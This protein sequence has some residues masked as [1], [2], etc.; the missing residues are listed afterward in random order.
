MSS[1]ENLSK[2]KGAIAWM[3]QNPVASN[4]FMFVLLFAGAVGL[5]QTKQEVLPEFDIGI[6][7]VIVPYPGAA[8]EEVEQ[9]IVLA[10]EEAV[11]GID[12]VKRVTGTAAENSGSVVLEL[13]LGADSN[14]VLN[15][16]KSAVDRI[17]TFPKDAEEP[18]VKELSLRRGVISLILS[19]DQELKTLHELAEQARKELRQDPNIT[20]ID[21]LGVPPREL[22]ITVD[23]EVLRAHSLTLNDIS[24]QI[25]ASSLELPGG[26]IKTKGGEL[27]VRLAD[28]KKSSDDFAKI[29]IRSSYD[30]AELRLS[31][32]ATISDGYEDN[33]QELFYN[34]KRAVQLAVYRIGQETP[35][36]VADAVKGYSEELR[37]TLPASIEVSYWND[38]SELL[39]GRIKLLLDNARIGLILVF[40]I[41]ALFLEFRLA[42][43]VAL[44]IPIS[45]LGSFILLGN[46][47]ATVNMVSLFAYIVTLGLVVDDAIVVGENIY[48]EHENGMDWLEASIVGAQKMVV[49]VTFAIL[50]SIAAFAPLLIV[51]G[52][53]GKFFKLIPIVV[54]SVLILSLIESFFVLPAHLGHMKDQKDSRFFWYINAPQRW[55]SKKLQIFID[56][57]FEKIIRWCT[58]NRYISFTSAIAMF[59]L[60]IGMVAGGKV[61]FSFFPKLDG[62]QITVSA[63]LP[64]GAPIE[65]TKMVQKEI[66]AA[67]YRALDRFGGKDQLLRG[68]LSSAGQGAE[69][70][71]G[72]PIGS[73]LTTVQLSLV[74][75]EERSITTNE[76][77]DAWREELPDLPGVESLKLS[78]QVGPGAGSAAVDVQIV[79]DD[80]NVLKEVS[81][82]LT[83]R[84][85]GYKS[86]ANIE[87]SL[88]SGKK[89]LDFQLNDQARSLGLT[90]TDVALQLRGSFFG[91]EALREQEGR[92]ERKVMVRLPKDQ[93]GTEADINEVRIRTPMGSF[94]PFEQLVD[95]TRNQ[96]PTVISRE[97]GVRKVNVRAELAPG[98][99]S[100]Q[101]TISS[102]TSKD[103]VELT[104]KYPGIELSL[105]GEQ[106]DQGETMASLGRNFLL[107][108]FAIYSLLAIPFR[109]Y[110]Q[111]FIIMSAIPFG[112]V[113]AIMGHVIMDYTMSVISMFG[114]IA[115][116]GVVV[117]DSLVLIDATNEYRNQG[118]SPMEAV[119][120]G[121]KRRLRPI[122]LTSFTTFLG[123]APMILE[124]STQAKF[125]IPMAIS[126]GFGVLFATFII[127]LVVPALYMILEDI[128]EPFPWQK[129][130]DSEFDDVAADLQPQQPIV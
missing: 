124:K 74:P 61:P 29:V 120:Q 76:I 59:L 25:R 24:N 49:P 84:L 105:A 110:T 32:I 127:L 38:Q 98:V 62:E 125:L 36:A 44:G 79:A 17:T 129:K 53:S 83:K 78:A 96:S 14:Q 37:K 85:Q 86:L 50:T 13:L 94:V 92:S 108:L 68:V 27:L 106:R 71:Q 67:A 5:L 28:R 95:Y 15:D 128:L 93:R 10:L 54:I 40:L 34:G 77:S 56:G 65:Q 117:N 81:D 57:P 126:L 47:D 39:K 73:H 87:N 118:M 107:A 16:V 48:E 31:D 109:S 35:T 46:T 6:I 102:L 2:Y 114:I 30:G 33:D 7:Q 45:F 26:G 75:S 8:P 4:L 121:A 20:Q 119:I 100:S 22:T 52:V 55:V 11:N 42:F 101:E 104:E 88:S 112:F 111:P 9:G 21:I 115:L 123:L 91:A 89:Q 60:T 113:G 80:I 23:R 99:K 43:W 58:I 1:P 72:V 130:A 82:D 66:E 116:T 64:Y 41:L 19:G 12:G 103:F 51:P 90:S 63:K 3:A 18:T 70:R 69:S 122:L 97:E